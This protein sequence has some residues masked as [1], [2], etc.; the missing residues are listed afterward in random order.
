MGHPQK[1]RAVFESVLITDPRA[2]EA[3]VGAGAAAMNTGDLH[4]AERLLAEA[5][6]IA[7]ESA[8]VLAAQGR[9]RRRTGHLRLALAILTA[10]YF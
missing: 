2:V 9:L 8:D 1:A 6:K 7:P 10:R 4:T 3:L 5:E